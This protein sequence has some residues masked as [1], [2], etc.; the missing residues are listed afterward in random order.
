MMSCRVG[1]LAFP[2]HNT[3]CVPHNQC[4][5]YLTLGSEDG[6]LIRDIPFSQNPSGGLL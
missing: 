5:V 1:G 2:P 6:G 3:C 4:P